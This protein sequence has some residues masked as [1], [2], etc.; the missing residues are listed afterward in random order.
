MDE[1]T[2]RFEQEME[3]LNKADENIKK[4]FLQLANRDFD[5]TFLFGAGIARRSCAL[6]AGFKSMIKDKNSVCALALVRMQL[7][8]SLRLYAGF[9]SK[10]R[11][12]FSQDVLKGIQINKMRADDNQKMSDNYLAKRVSEIN[13]WVINVYRTTSGYVHFSETHIKGAFKRKDGNLFEMI[14]GPNDNDRDPN[15]F[16]ESLQ[17]F[18]HITMM[19]EVQLQDWFGLLNHDDFSC[20]APSQSKNRP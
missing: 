20:Q 18:T 11:N 3:H 9:F 16:L 5:Y 6:T 1:K 10:D 19:I 14:I 15:D 7:D 2:L 13:P 17:C 4:L 12:K 8:N